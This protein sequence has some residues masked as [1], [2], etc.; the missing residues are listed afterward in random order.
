MGGSMYVLHVREGEVRQ[1]RYVKGDGVP[2]YLAFNTDHTMSRTIESIDA[3]SASAFDVAL[4]QV[5]PDLP[6][7]CLTQ[8]AALQAA[9]GTKS[10][11]LSSVRTLSLPA[12][13]RI[14]SVD[15]IDSLRQTFTSLKAF[16][17][18]VGISLAVAF[19]SL[20]ASVSGVFSVTSEGL[21]R[22]VSD[23]P[24]WIWVNR[25]EVVGVAAVAA[26]LYVLTSSPG[27]EHVV[28]SSGETTDYYTTGRQ[29]TVH[30]TV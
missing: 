13:P 6:A 26:P 24:M 17:D 4:T 15:P 9:I 5:S 29:S 19:G 12:L 23:G 14:G 3:C 1:A 30:T 10:Y 27:S 18:S 11:V 7:L 16:G 8:K 21:R 20:T 25:E 28:D 2:F 22:L